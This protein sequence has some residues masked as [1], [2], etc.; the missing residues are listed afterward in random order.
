MSYSINN[1][2]H[3]HRY[4]GGRRQVEEMMYFFWETLYRRIVTR[5]KVLIKGKLIKDYNVRIFLDLINAAQVCGV[6][7]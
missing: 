5:Y 6:S 3:K 7:R 1:I 2:Q 4:S